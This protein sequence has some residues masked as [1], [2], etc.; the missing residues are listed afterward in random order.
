MV[1]HLP[2]TAKPFIVIAHRGASSTEPENTL[3]A[4]RRAAALG[5][6]WI[7][8]D[9]RLTG[10]RVPVIIHDATVNRTTN[11]RG[12][13]SRMTNY[14]LRK[15]DAR[16]EEK[17]P[18]LKETLQFAKKNRIKFV[19]EI[20]NSRVLNKTISLLRAFK[21]L[22]RIILSSF[23]SPVILRAKK[24]CPSL[25]TALIIEYPFVDWMRAARRARADMVHVFAPLVAREKINAAHAVGLTVWAWTVN[26]IR[27]AHDLK[28]MGVNG[29][30]TDNP[31]LF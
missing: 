31:H 29:I 16:K 28:K 21:L 30:F 12:R 6:T 2:V 20:K 15:L 8:C 11:G 26:N 4:F 1:I 3:R 19:L 23:S 7:E 25:T 10:D 5:C 22:N 18:S 27:R 17:I 13:I 24:L 14:E 9:V